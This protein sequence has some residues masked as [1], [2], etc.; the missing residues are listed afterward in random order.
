LEVEYNNDE[1]NFLLEL[2][3]Q[4]EIWDTI[5]VPEL[6]NTSND[7][8][9]KRFLTRDARYSGLL[10]KLQVVPYIELS[11]V[12]DLLRNKSVNTWIAFNVER[13][14][15]SNLARAAT[16][17]GVKRVIVTT[18]MA[19]KDIN[20]TAIPEFQDAQSEFAKSGAAFTGIRHGS[21]ITGTEDNSY[22]I[23][24][25]TVPL[26]EGEVERGVL[27]RVIAE[28]VSIE[29]SFNDSCGV[30]SSSPFAAAYLNILRSSGLNRKQ[31]VKK[32]Y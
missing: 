19:E 3:N 16:E 11:G 22:E 32:M 6:S 12:V 23:V 9:K 27:S 31:E 10:D 30:C 26:L 21:I 5:V 14:S 13:D 29:D 24:N 25:S 20:V 7:L 4:Q 2:F 17:A 1:D 18:E 28:L 8:L 15:I